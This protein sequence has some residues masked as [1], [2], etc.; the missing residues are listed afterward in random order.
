MAKFITLDTFKA[1]VAKM[2]EKFLTKT[3]AD[4]LYLTSDS[5]NDFKAHIIEEVKTE[6][7]D[8][9]KNLIQSAVEESAKQN[10]QVITTPKAGTFSIIDSNGYVT[11][12]TTNLAAKWTAIK[13]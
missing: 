9:L 6:I 4:Q 8:D 13:V 11:I 1:A 3:D 2:K 5:F 12:D 7:A 10:G